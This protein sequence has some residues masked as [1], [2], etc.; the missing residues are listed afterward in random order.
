MIEVTYCMRRKAGLSH[1]EFVAHWED[2]HVPI[3]LDNLA[4][5][6]LALYQRTVPLQH[7]FSE[8]VE[9]RRHMQA[10]FDGIARLAWATPEDMR[11]AFE[12]PHALAVQRLLAQDEALFVD[13]AGSCRW[14]SRTVRH[15]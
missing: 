11:M 10:P 5:L 14:V 13:P 1:E 7:D 6:R 8:R 15:L 2:V 12:D 4:V 3:V 9:R